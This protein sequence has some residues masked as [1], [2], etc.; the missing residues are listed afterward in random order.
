MAC[1]AAPRPPQF[2][3]PRHGHLGFLPKKRTKRHQ[4]KVKS[5]PRDDASKPCH[6]TA[7]MGQCSAVGGALLLQQR[8]LA[9]AAALQ[10]RGVRGG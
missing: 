8:L 2:E 9:A 3:H 5:F 10:E 7:F 6:F 1:R 4:G